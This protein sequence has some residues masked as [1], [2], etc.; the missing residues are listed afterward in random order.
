M[1]RGQWVSSLRIHGAW[2][3]RC[4]HLPHLN[5]ACSTSPALISIATS[6]ISTAP[7]GLAASPSTTQTR[8]EER[9]SLLQELGLAPSDMALLAPSP[10]C[11]LSPACGG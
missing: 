4:L 9:L 3:I 6:P 5:C 10:T 8:Y 1:Q 2:A 11:S 7:W